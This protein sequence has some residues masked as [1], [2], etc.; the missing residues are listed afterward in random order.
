[1]KVNFITRTSVSN[2]QR[3]VNAGINRALG[4]PVHQGSGRLA[5]V[6]GGPSI[7]DH[8][9]TLRAWDGEVWA[10]NGTIDWCIRHSLDAAFYTIDASPQPNWPYAL[11]GVKRAVISVECDPSMFAHL[12]GARIE[13]MEREEVGPTSAAAAAAL[14]L[15]CG[16]RE[17]VFF[18]CES[19]FGESTHA[20]A[21]ANVTDWMDIEVGGKHFRT[22][23]EFADQAATLAAVI[24]ECPQVYSE[25]SGG[26]LAA[27]IERGADY[28]V[29]EM[30]DQLWG[31][32]LKKA[33]WMAQV[34]A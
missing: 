18:G 15:I 20:Y 9:E 10:V 1:M 8:I 17:I 24:R 31:G 7:A 5:V 33:E 21:A 4:L 16:Y 26:L 2:E 14:G 11:K 3:G 25:R 22:K 30:S 34:G 19:S 28:E 32:P 27:M 23:P 12:Q 6:G 29:V 13:V